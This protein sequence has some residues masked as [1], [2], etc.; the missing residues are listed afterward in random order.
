M[1]FNLL[2]VGRPSKEKGLQD[3][4]EALSQLSEYNWKLTIVGQI[5]NEILISH[6]SLKDRLILLGPIPNSAMPDIL[7]N[8]DIL[9]VPS[10]YESFGNIIIEGM[11]CGIT[12][13]ASKTGGIK[14]IIKHNYN[15]L[16]V[17]PKNHKQLTNRIV[18]LFESPSQME[19][20]S[21]NALSCSNRYD[22]KNIIS[23]TLELFNRLL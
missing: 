19:V 16:F 18:S 17:D 5:P 2:F 1:T 21:N 11:A 15:G 6:F 7:N 23:E 4:L 10:H 9:I 20:L 13:I 3:L 12:I 14:N 22:W 8:H